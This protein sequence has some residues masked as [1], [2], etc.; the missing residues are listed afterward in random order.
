M[1]DELDLTILRT[2]IKASANKLKKIHDIHLLENLPKNKRIIYKQEPRKEN[3]LSKKSG[4]IKFLKDLLT[5]PL[6]E[7]DH[8]Q[9]NEISLFL[10]EILIKELKK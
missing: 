4:R 5:L 6:S 7:D 3:D 9:N 8:E 1:V 2:P 10:K